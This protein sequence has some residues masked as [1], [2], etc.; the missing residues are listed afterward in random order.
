MAEIF[1]LPNIFDQSANSCVLDSLYKNGYGELFEY[2]QDACESNRH[3]KSLAPAEVTYLVLYALDMIAQVR[4]ITTLHPN[5]IIYVKRRLDLE[6]CKMM[7]LF[8]E[9][10]N[11]ELKDRLCQTVLCII[12]QLLAKIGYLDINE[13]RSVLYDC[14]GNTTPPFLI[15]HVDI[16]DNIE[17][18][19]NQK[20]ELINFVK[21]F[22]TVEEYRTYT[23]TLKIDLLKTLIQN[24]FTS[25]NYI[26]IATIANAITPANI[27]HIDVIKSFLSDLLDQSKIDTHAKEQARKQI[28]EKVDQIK[29]YNTPQQLFTPQEQTNQTLQPKTEDFIKLLS[30]PYQNR[31]EDCKKLLDILT[32]SGWSKKDHARFAL[33]LYKSGN[34]ALQRENIR[35]FAEWWR[36][37]CDIFGW[38]GADSPYKE[39]QLTPNKATRQISLYL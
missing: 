10:S 2:V 35:T 23:S 15:V 17:S 28:K 4:Q 27:H 21:N 30:I 19:T 16:I 7:N 6:S 5:H 14:K 8:H 11:E 13:M 34:V 1:I 25:S 24:Q 9:Y 39:S 33:A 26:E 18:L 37:C 32:Q 36:I 22:I 29:A 38:E 31:K 3:T 12:I 20:E